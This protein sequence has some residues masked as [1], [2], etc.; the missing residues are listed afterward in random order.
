M[1]L[2][3]QIEELNLKAE[4]IRALIGR[5]YTIYGR[6][7]QAENYELVMLAVP[8]FP[9][10][11]EAIATGIELDTLCDVME[12]Y[13]AAARGALSDVECSPGYEPAER[14]DS[15]DSAAAT[16]GAGEKEPGS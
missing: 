15:P 7:L 6:K 13:V 4:K 9:G 2:T 1:E 11:I 16:D 3:E 10:N 5:A 8:M 12:A 14:D